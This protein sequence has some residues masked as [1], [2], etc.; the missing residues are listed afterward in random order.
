MNQQR[1]C[2]V[3]AHPPRAPTVQRCISKR[4]TGAPDNFLPTFNHTRQ[5]NSIAARERILPRESYTPLHQE[6][7]VCVI[8]N[9]VPIHV[10]VPGLGMPISSTVTDCAIGSTLLCD[11]SYTVAL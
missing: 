7:P 8:R 3:L 6:L 2:L 5:S 10:L 1:F 11:L 9:G 4:T